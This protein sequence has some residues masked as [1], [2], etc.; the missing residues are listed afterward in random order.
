MLQGRDGRVNDFIDEAIFKQDDLAATLRLLCLQVRWAL[1]I[2]DFTFQSLPSFFTFGR[3]VALPLTLLL[4]SFPI[5]LTFFTFGQISFGQSLT[6]NGL[7]RYSDYRRE[8]LHTYGFDTI[9]TLNNL[10][11]IGIFKKQEGRCRRL[12]VWDCW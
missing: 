12:W 5:T 1:G 3:T 9:F 7:K 10:E 2:P 11:K 8:L 4:C 6:N